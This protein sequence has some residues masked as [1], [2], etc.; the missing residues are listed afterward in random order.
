MLVLKHMQD[1]IKIEQ[2]QCSFSKLTEDNQFFVLGLAEGLK[3][4]QDH[5]Y[6]EP[7]KMEMQ[8]SKKQK[9]ITQFL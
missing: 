5:K 7:P 4:A 3:H 9:V 1:N 8:D 2:L 6:K